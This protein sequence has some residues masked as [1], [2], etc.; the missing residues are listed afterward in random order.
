M[1]KPDLDV[2]GIGNAIVD[3]LAKCDDA[4]LV[5]HSITKGGMVLIEDDQAT[6]IYNAMSAMGECVEVSGGSAAN[7]IACIA[8]LGGSGGFVGKVA[9]DDLGR[10]FRKDLQSHGV[11]FETTPL[12]EGGAGTGRCLINVTPDA[13]R[14]M[15]T[16]LGA[17]GD[18]SISDI[19]EDQIK[20]AKIIFFEGYMFEQ[21]VAR[22]AFVKACAI[23]RSAGRKSALT[24]SDTGCVDRQHEVLTSFIPN[25]VDILLANE[26]EAQTLFETNKID[27]IENRARAMCPMTV[28]T[29]SAKGSLII[30][31]DQETVVVDAHPP[32]H[33]VDTTGAGDAYAA[34][35]L[36][37]IAKGY[38]LTIAGALGSIAAS[39]VISQMGP[40]PE[41]LLKTLA[42]KAGLL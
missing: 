4:F 9:D 5:S 6:Q 30:A 2:V 22:E 15:M 8:S 32:T 13:E 23:A 20:R 39:E 18:V 25:H 34:G 21:P 7:S 10:T 36:F 1:A 28:V 37:A 26:A 29:L 31:R 41:Q 11:E 35:F 33:L 17:A 24:L 40:R 19:D 12:P 42:Q 14:S 27:E 38:D 16:F 3:V